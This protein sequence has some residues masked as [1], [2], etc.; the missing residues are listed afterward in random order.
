MQN[1]KTQLCNELRHGTIVDD[2]AFQGVMMKHCLVFLCMTHL[3]VPPLFQLDSFGSF[4][5]LFGG[6]TMNNP[7]QFD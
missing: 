1:C 2:I 3:G 4:I 6:G 5:D 7:L